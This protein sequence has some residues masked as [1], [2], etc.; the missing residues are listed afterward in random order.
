MYEQLLHERGEEKFG[1]RRVTLLKAQNMQMERQLSLLSE[2]TD[3]R[4][5]ALHELAT[6]VTGLEASVRDAQQAEAT[7]A[8]TSAA[9]GAKAQRK[10]VNLEHSL[11]AAKQRVGPT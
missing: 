1:A 10:L 6:V 4:R 3:T 7:S 11:E 8:A 5:A 9:V 2:G